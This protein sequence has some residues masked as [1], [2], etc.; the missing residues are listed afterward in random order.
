MSD[1]GLPF[2]Q[3]PGATID[4]RTE[5][6]S[7]NHRPVVVIGDPSTNTGIAPVDATYGLGADIKRVGADFSIDVARGVVTNYALV[8]VMGHNN[9]VGTSI[10]DV[11]GNGGTYVFPSSASTLTISSGSTNDT[12]AGTGARTVQVYGLDTNYAEIN[13]TLTMNGQSGV[14]STNSY[15]RVTKMLVRTAGSTGGNAGNVYF[16]TGTI[17][18]GVPATIYSMIAYSA[19][20][21]GDNRSLDCIY[22]VPAGK[23]A[24]IFDPTINL[25]SSVQTEWWLKIRP[26][27]EVFQTETRRMAF[28]SQVVADGHFPIVAAA[29]SDIK[30]SAASGSSNDVA[31]HL[32]II[33]IG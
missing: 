1:A 19:S 25:D 24:Y 27:D 17:T 4:S 9:A 5:S 22:T 15:L 14:T 3:V 30:M 13:E 2:S 26:L 33:L 31:A 23:T 7:G 11:W 12:S 18:A 21:G 29:K 20:Y 10:E 28:Q 8:R 32:T 6:T 16:G